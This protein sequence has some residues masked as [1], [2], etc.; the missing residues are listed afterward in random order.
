MV[1]NRRAGY[2]RDVGH[3]EGGGEDVREWSPHKK[4][5]G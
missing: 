2:A 4:T 3:N 1:G 5:S